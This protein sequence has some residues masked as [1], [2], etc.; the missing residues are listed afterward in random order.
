MQQTELVI[1]FLV[2]K[3][4]KEKNDKSSSDIIKL[5]LIDPAIN[6]FIAFR[7]R[8]ICD[9][10]IAMKINLIK[11]QIVQLS[12]LLILY[13]LLCRFFILF[14]I[15]CHCWNPENKYMNTCTLNRCLYI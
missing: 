13:Y 8:L 2:E 6:W 7:D 14:F 1:Q 5:I 15:T 3:G 12:D 10:N 4:R 9:M 11:S